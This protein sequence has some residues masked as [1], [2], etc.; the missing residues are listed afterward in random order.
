MAKITVTI[1]T[2]IPGEE[3]TP[4]LNS[5]EVEVDENHLDTVE[6]EYVP[7]SQGGPLMRPKA[8]PR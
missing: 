1:S 4:I 2:S 8:P 6:L 7:L 5:F 3:S